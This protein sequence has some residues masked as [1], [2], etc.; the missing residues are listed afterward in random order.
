MTAASSGAE[1][2]AEEAAGRREQQRHGEEEG[3]GERAH[4]RP[5]EPPVQLAAA[6]VEGE[7]LGHARGAAV[8]EAELVAEVGRNA[9][10][11]PR[12]D[13]DGVLLD[14]ADRRDGRGRAEDRPREPPQLRAAE[15]ERAAEQVGGH[16]RE[17]VPRGQEDRVRARL[18]VQQVLRDQ[19]VEDDE[20]AERER[21][22]VD[23]PRPERQRAG[24]HRVERDAAERRRQ[25]QLLPRLDHV[26]REARDA[27]A[28]EQRHDEV[29]EREPDGERVER[30][31]RPAPD[32]DEPDG[33]R[34]QVDE[35]RERRGHQARPRRRKTSVANRYGASGPVSRARTLRPACA[36]AARQLVV[37]HARAAEGGG[38]VGAAAGKRERGRP[39]SAPGAGHE[40]GVEDGQLHE[41]LAVRREDAAELA[42]VPEH[43]AHARQ[44]LE[45]E[46]TDERVDAPVRDALEALARDRAELD[47]RER[48]G[49]AR[50]S[51]HHRRDVE[52]EDAVEPLGERGGHPAGSASDLHRETAAWVGAEPAEEG[53]ELLPPACG[54]ADVRRGVAGCERVPCLAHVALHGG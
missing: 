19:R 33:Q 27:G 24:A 6:G 30:Q 21:E 9:G 17:R 18:A 2:A 50:A 10:V 25:Q 13:R 11:A 20:P 38:A 8:L 3:R 52:A 41:R 53:V 49:L 4:E 36:Q 7:V 14:Q 22:Q 16:G 35:E 23:E 15:H 43:V 51:D 29:V 45:H 12:L 32:G 40:A 1:P 39:G 28:V 37:R 46:V 44:M 31:H 34:G 54:I 5:D 26:E 42:E 47:G 48:H